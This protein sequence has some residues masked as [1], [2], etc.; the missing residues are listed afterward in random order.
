M[1]A[2]TPTPITNQADGPLLLTDVQA[3]A[4]IG[5]SRRTLWALVSKGEFPAP[6]R[7]AGLRMTRW[8]REEIEW[9][10]SQL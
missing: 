3:A 6:V 10:V 5:I 1:I 9:W 4:R 8:K 2:L 7:V